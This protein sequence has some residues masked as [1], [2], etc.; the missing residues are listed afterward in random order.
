MNRGGESGF[1]RVR[2][3]NPDLEI[4]TDEYLNYR[5][6]QFRFWGMLGLLEISFAKFLDDPERYLQEAAR[7]VGGLLVREVVAYA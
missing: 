2:K 5:A 7:K 4:L 3:I 6:E 1:P